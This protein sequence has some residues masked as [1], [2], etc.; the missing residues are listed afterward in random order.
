VHKAL[1]STKQEKYTKCLHEDARGL[2][3]GAMGHGDVDS[4]VQ[5]EK[6]YSK[7]STGR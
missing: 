2:I 6:K 5:S 7:E 3:R 1:E 4:S